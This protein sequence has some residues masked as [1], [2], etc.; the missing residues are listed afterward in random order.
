MKS[1]ICIFI[2]DSNGCYPVPASKG[3]AVSTLVEQLVDGNNKK[4]LCDMTIVSYYDKKAFELSKKYSNI[5][6]IW[7]KIPWIIQQLDNVLFWVISTF[8]KIKAISFKSMGALLFYTLKSSF[9]IRK[10]HYTTIVLEHNIPM[11]WMIRI[12]RYKGKYFHHLHNLPRTNAKCKKGLN[13]C[14]GFL[15]ISQYMADYIISDKSPIN[16]IK[17]SK[18][19]LLYNCIDTT[20]FRPIPKNDLLFKKEDFCI[21]KN[22]KIIIFAGRVTWEKGVDKV[23]EA[24]NFIKYKD[25][26]VLIVGSSST[27]RDNDSYFRYINKLSNMYKNHIHYTGYID[28]NNLPYLYN[29]ADVAVLP[30]I[31]EEP[32]GLTMLEAMACGTPV[33]TTF[34]GGIP[35]YVGNSAIV[36]NRDEKLP[37]EIAR[38]IDILLTDRDK[39]NFY[40]QKGIER[41]QNMFSSE[42]YIDKFC[43]IVCT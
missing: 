9:L 34:S 2:A 43:S 18:I 8:T 30:S 32:A 24:L 14:C 11:T 13:K 3:G 35:E 4:H 26:E 17:A 28:H 40:S 23:L 39:Y 42:N 25:V 15:C 20:L 19:K 21:S 5:D 1:R 22:S 38:N 6:F 12:S 41:I 33:I 37:Q 36:L 29:L 31:W 27:N 10:Q 7:I 16:H